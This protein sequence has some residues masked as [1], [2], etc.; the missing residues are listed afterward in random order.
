MIE[1]K[2]MAHQQEFCADYTTP[3]LALIGGFGCG[4]T[5]A[6]CYKT[7]IMAGL[8]AGYEGAIAEPTQYLVRTHLMPNMEQVLLDMKIPYDLEKSHGIFHIHFKE[9][10]TKIYCL[11]GENYQRLV[12]YNLA[13]F[14]SDETDT[15][16]HEIAQEMWNKA[17]SRV[18]TGPHRQIYS[19]S[20]PEGYKFLYDF[21][22]TKAA[23][24]RKTIHASSYDNPLLPLDFLEQMKSNYTPQQWEVWAMGQFGNLTSSKVYDAFDRV[25]NHSD[26]SLKDIPKHVQICIGMDFNIDH[27][28][29]VA[30]VMTP[31]GPIA[32]KE[33][34]NIKDV[35]TMII[36]LHTDPD[37]KGRTKVVYPDAAGNQRNAGGFDSS[38]TMLR[39]AGFN[40]QFRPAN[41]RVGDRINSMNAMFLNANGDRRYKVNTRLCP[42]YT[43]CLEQ[44]TRLP[45]GEPD[46]SN[47][48]DHPLDA[49]GYF[50]YW[51]YPLQGKPGITTH[52]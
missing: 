25:L 23:P 52:G 47:N 46:K 2:L 28:A 30:H 11:S 6:F 21:F 35:P 49:A 39:D 14:G 19:T 50:I 10:T 33:F 38:I 17:I 40:P 34:V 27:M 42:T 15:S 12:G 41:P 4:K 16:G 13:F 43:R 44:Q 9:G 22:V 1:L 31:D 29:A 32:V 3:Y 51:H 20:T 5:K 36:T 8:N 18:R 7:V 24:D 45:N 48:I 37:L 26:I